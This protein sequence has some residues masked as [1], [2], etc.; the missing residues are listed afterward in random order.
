LASRAKNL[1]KL[2]P[3]FAPQRRHY[4]LYPQKITRPINS[5]SSEQLRKKAMVSS[6]NQEMLPPT[7]PQEGQEA[8]PRFSTETPI[9]ALLE[10]NRAWADRQERLNPLL[11]PSLA[12]SQHPHIL[13]IGCSDSRVPE[14][15]VLDLLPGDLF[16]H[17]NIAN[18]VS[19]GDMSVLSVVQFAV[20]VLGVSH[21][22]VCGIPFPC[23]RANR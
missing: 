7:P 17:R 6:G 5:P 15:T 9:S 10:R 13:W 8:F 14:T 21:I 3:G 20:E 1:K 22:V 18:V 23:D 2:L 11:F 19:A 4:S 12:H 16:V